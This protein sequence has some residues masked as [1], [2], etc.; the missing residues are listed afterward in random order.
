MS[1]KQPVSF[2]IIPL[3]EEPQ[4]TYKKGSKYDPIIDSFIE[5][6]HPLGQIRVTKEDSSELLNANYLRTQLAKRIIAR[7]LTSTVV[8]SVTNNVCYLKRL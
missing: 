2:K 8:A 4:R 5:G 3:D 1:K 6:K 7:E